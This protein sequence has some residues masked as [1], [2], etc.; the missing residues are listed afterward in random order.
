M[1]ITKKIGIQSWND[2]QEMIA[3]ASIFCKSSA[4]NSLF[5]NAISAYSIY[6][7]QPIHVKSNR[8]VRLDKPNGKN[9]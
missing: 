9:E 4:L 2:V 5:G 6:A 8:Y 7:N 3:K 1:K